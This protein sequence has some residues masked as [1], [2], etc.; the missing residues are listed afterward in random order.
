M[1]QAEL[2]PKDR[3]ERKRRSWHHKGHHTVQEAVAC[4]AKAKTQDALVLEW[5][6]AFPEARVTPWALCDALEGKLLL[7]SCR[8]AL[9]NLTQA[10]LLRRHDEDRRPGKAGALNATWSLR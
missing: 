6:R 2:F 5:F 3:P 4:E 8:R 9:T 10:G 7:T 1:S